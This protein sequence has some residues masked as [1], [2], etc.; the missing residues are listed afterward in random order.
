M[1]YYSRRLPGRHD[2]NIESFSN[3]DDYYIEPM[4]LEINNHA[5]KSWIDD[6]FLKSIEQYWPYLKRIKYHYDI[7]YFGG[8]WKYLSS[9]PNMLI[10]VG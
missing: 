10:N 8:S 5:L 3:Q 9:F 7:L 2:C 4:T 1:S 6:S